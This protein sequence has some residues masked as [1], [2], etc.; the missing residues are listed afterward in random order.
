MTRR[1]AGLAKYISVGGLYLIIVPLLFMGIWGAWVF[2]TAVSKSITSA[3]ELGTRA[4]AWRLEEFLARPRQA[5][6]RIVSIVENEDLHPRSSM[7]A[8]LREAISIYPFIDQIQV[9][10]PEGR[11]RWLAPFDGATEGSLRTGESVYE[12]IL[13]SKGIYWSP[14]YISLRRNS[15]AVSFGIRAG[16]SVILCDLN[17]SSIGRFA[18]PYRDQAK[19][20][21]EISIID[22]HGVYLANPDP[23]KVLRREQI[24]GFSAIKTGSM[25]SSS[26]PVLLGGKRHLASIVVTV[27]P[28]WY[29]VML[30]PMAHMSAVLGRY[31]LGFLCLLLASA[32]FGLLVSHSGIRRIAEALELLTRKTKRISEGQYED[33]VDFGRG[34]REFE[35]LGKDF[36]GMIGGIRKREMELLDRERGFRQIL[37]G[38]HLLVLGLDL[39]GRISFAN[40]CFLGKLEYG[41][42]ELA[43][44]PLSMLLP[45]GTEAGAL[46]F[47]TAGRKDNVAHFFECAVCTKGGEER[48][49][50]WTITENHDGS[51]VLSGI[52]GIGSDITDFKRQKAL[53]ESSL[54][55]KGVLLREVHHRVKNNLQLISSLLQLQKEEAG[56]SCADTPLESAQRRI[57]SIALVHEMLYATDDLGS[58]DFGDYVSAL[59]REALMAAEEGNIELRLDVHTFQLSLDEAVPCGLIL[60]EALTNIR[61]YAFPAGWTRSR[62]VELSLGQ[63]PGGIARLAIKDNGI[64]LPPDYD[65]GTS[66]SLGHTIIRLLA[67]QIGADLAIHTQDGTLVELRFSPRQRKR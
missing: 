36:N 34:F 21:Y 57:K 49:V 63:E 9:I 15:P 48:C 14:S 60:N 7:D 32:I 39:E 47:L 28:S 61:K 30:Y 26:F 16:S 62:I 53:L 20:D 44:R 2:E 38:I 54:E 5:L 46:P 42:D 6:D 50:E 19:P 37:E 35:E 29:V 24:P 31:L 59:G 66:Q 10:G 13:A 45:V 17:L 33:L 64:G 43:G 22:G 52:T 65:P 55:E 27:D 11:V 4:V 25:T 1:S 3:N 58:F 8:L 12:G 40:P 23:S 51:G 56:E 18:Q 67:Q 41:M